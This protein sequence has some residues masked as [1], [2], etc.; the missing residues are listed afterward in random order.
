MSIQRSSLAAIKRIYRLGKLILPIGL[1]LHLFLLTGVASAGARTSFH[2]DDSIQ[3][4]ADCLNYA[5]DESASLQFNSPLLLDLRGQSSCSLN[6]PHYLFNGIDPV[7]II[8][9]GK[10]PTVHHA[11][12]EL[13]GTEVG[14]DACQYIMSEPGEY[15][16][17]FVFKRPVTIELTISNASCLVQAA[18]H[19]GLPI[20]EA[21]DRGYAEVI[22]RQDLGDILGGSIP[23]IPSILIPSISSPI[24]FVGLMATLFVYL[25]GRFNVE[26]SGD[27]SRLEHASSPWRRL[28]RALKTKRAHYLLLWT[29]TPLALAQYAGSVQQTAYFAWS[30]LTCFALLWASYFFD[31]LQ[32]ARRFWLK[33][34]LFMIG[35]AV[36]LPIAVAL[37]GALPPFNGAT[38]RVGL[39]DYRSLGESILEVG[40]V[41]ELVKALPLILYIYFARRQPKLLFPGAQD[42]VFMGVLV[43]L[44]FSIAEGV[45]LANQGIMY[46]SGTTMLFRVISGPVLHACWTG[47]TA[48]WLDVASR[49]PATKG[50]FIGL[51]AILLT[52]TLHGIY[53][54]Y[55]AEPIGVGVAAFIIVTFVAHTMRT[56]EIRV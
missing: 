23:R 39:L 45:R 18:I 41:E 37:V 13:S 29:L 28:L 4:G 8:I 10:C 16:L 30:V 55:A 11:G 56:E 15:R 46:F 12:E 7:S 19:Y 31:Y 9:V 52:G 49:K 2:L 44:G 53:N 24:L 42:A 17:E 21:V 26:T 54:S 47:I 43:G 25:Q 27:A 32:P 40:L 33:G 1:L 50:V 38:S 22:C 3:I 36:I 35:A 14:F 20:S 6:L 51:G 48:Y 5:V 34:I